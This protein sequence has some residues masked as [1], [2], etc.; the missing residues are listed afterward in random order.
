MM[1]DMEKAKDFI[2]QARKLDPGN[3]NVRFVESFSK[4]DLGPKGTYSQRRDAYRLVANSLVSISKRDLAVAQIMLESAHDLLP[5]DWFIGMFLQEL[6][7]YR[8]GL[9][10]SDTKKQKTP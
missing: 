9:A 8:K 7:D 10:S 3:N 6:H 2:A 5:D 4:M 1:G